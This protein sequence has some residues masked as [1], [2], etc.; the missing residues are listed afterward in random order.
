MRSLVPVV[1]VAIALVLPAS[2]AFA[3]PADQRTGLGSGAQTVKVNPS[4]VAGEDGGGEP[5]GYIVV[6]LGGFAL[7]AAGFAGASGARRSRRVLEA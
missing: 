4:P 5:L 3:R 2:A 6:G 1:T 7:G